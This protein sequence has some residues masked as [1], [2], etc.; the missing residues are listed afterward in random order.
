[1]DRGQAGRLDE[2]SLHSSSGGTDH[3]ETRSGII[4]ETLFGLDSKIG[5]ERGVEIE[6]N[7]A[8]RED[9]RIR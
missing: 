5:R 7:Y 8:P 1:M 4:C 2:I 3:I 6:N 9:M